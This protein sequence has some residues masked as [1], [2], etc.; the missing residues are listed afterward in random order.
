[1]GK[2]KKLLRPTGAE[3]CSS[4]KESSQKDTKGPLNVFVSYFPSFLPML[5]L[6]IIDTFV[7]N[8]EKGGVQM[9]YVWKVKTENLWKMKQN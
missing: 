1:M 2:S 3:I 9:T 6:S 4:S 5:I 8:K 7:Y